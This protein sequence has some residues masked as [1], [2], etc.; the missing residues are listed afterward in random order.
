MTHDY[1]FEHDDWAV[2]TDGMVIFGTLNEPVQVTIAEGATVT[3]RNVVINQDG[4]LNETAWTYTDA[5]P[6]LYCRDDATL[7]IADGSINLITGYTADPDGYYGYPGIASSGT[8]TIKGGPNGTGVLNVTG[9][10][11]AAGIG[12]GTNFTYNSPIGGNIIIQG[13]VIN[14]TGKNGGAG[15]GTGKTWADAYSRNYFGDITIT[16]GTITAIS[17]GNGAGIGSGQH[18]EIYPM[19]G[20]EILNPCGNITISGGTITAYSNG[21]GSSVGKGLHSSCGTITVDDVTTESI[22]ECFYYPESNP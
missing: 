20:N 2:A 6:G 4:S 13:G 19:S 15:I 16:G 14:A 10:A 17:E 5:F 3:L 18:Y 11:G 9:G 8:L 7:I 21:N 22:S 1:C 12:T